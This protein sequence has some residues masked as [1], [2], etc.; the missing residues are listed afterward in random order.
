MPIEKRLLDRIESKKKMLDAIRPLPEHVLGKLKEDLEIELTYNSNAIEGNTLTLQETKLILE[1]GITIKGK[2]MREHLEVINHKEAFLFLETLIKTKQKL[3]ED[4]IKDIHKI[5][6]TKINDKEAG[7][8]R[9]TNVRILGAIKSPP[10]YFKIQ[11]LMKEFIN[12][13]YQE[14]KILHPI[15]LAAKIHYGIAAIHPFFDGNGRTARLSMNLVLIQSGYPI[16][17]ILNND[18][19]KYYSVLKK[20][21]LDDFSPFLNFIARMVERSLNLYLSSFKRGMEL[22]SLKEATKY[23]PYSQE[24]LSLLSRRGALDGLKLGRSWYTTKKAI[25]DYMKNIRK[26]RI[27]RK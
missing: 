3:T 25:I 21:D 22:V 4:I 12:K 20:A 1:R 9:K 11:N 19:K 14:S 13:I 27:N 18:R 17:I 10:S 26:Y 23:C 7:H 5:I 15:E 8:Y 6:L 16:T 2:S 24:Y